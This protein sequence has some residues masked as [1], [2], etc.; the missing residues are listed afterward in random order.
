MKMA[1]MENDSPVKW[2]KITTPEI[3]GKMHYWKMMEWK[4]TDMGNG[5]KLQDWK[6][7]ENVPLENDGIENDSP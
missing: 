4:M 5:R 6:M 3:D 1:D 7:V 2:W